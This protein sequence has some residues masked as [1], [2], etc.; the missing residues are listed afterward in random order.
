MLMRH[1]ILTFGFDFRFCG[2]IFAHKHVFESHVRTHTGEKPFACM[3]CGRSFG[4]R[5]NRLSHQKKCTATAI[6]NSAD[7]PTASPGGPRKDLRPVRALPE[8]LAKIPA[9]TQVIP[10][11]NNARYVT[12]DKIR[13]RRQAL[14]EVYN[15]N[16]EEDEG[17][18]GATG[19]AGPQ[20]VSVESVR[21]GDGGGEDDDDED[22]EELEEEEIIVD[23]STLTDIDYD[24][25]IDDSVYDEDLEEIQVRTL[26][27]AS[28]HCI[29]LQ[30]VLVVT[31][32]HGKFNPLQIEP[33][34]IDYDGDDQS[35]STDTGPTN[36]NS[37][38][39]SSD[40]NRDVFTCS[41]CYDKFGRQ[42]AFLSHLV[43]AHLSSARFEGF[44]RGSS[45]SS[46]E[47]SFPQEDLERGYAV[48]RYASRVKY[49]CLSC[50]KQ[51]V[52][53]EH[54]GD[55]I[56]VHF[57]DGVYNCLHCDRVFSSYDVYETHVDSHRI[58][59]QHVCL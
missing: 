59:C 55:H 19:D 54:I 48:V 50:G 6:I 44:D 36:G 16:A 43:S 56:K 51:F 34:I 31:R 39:P 13:R 7:P 49:L 24:D 12:P 2:R 4:D 46:S 3:K 1:F 32:G 5:S 45:S 33:D 37:G 15:D 26:R 22:E 21:P 47:T 52:K 29:V 20:I 11:N 30:F 14:S 40:L 27:T 58:H 18:G 57:Q 42:T 23:P 8:R 53:E 25:I 28:L 17:S 9:N 38:A 10:N 41:H 35:S